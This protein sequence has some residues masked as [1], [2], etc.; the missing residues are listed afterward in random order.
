[1][2]QKRSIKR[3]YH[4][5]KWR[6][7]PAYLAL[8]GLCAAALLLLVPVAEASE[9]V[10]LTPEQRAYLAQLGPLTV[11]PDPDWMPFEFVDADGN[12]TGIAA[13]LLDL[14]EQRLGIEFSYVIPRD[15]DEA[16]EWSQA[17]EV[18]IL[19]FLNQSPAREEW[20]VF[21]EPLF[22]DPNVFITRNEHPFISDARQLSNETMVLPS[23][24]SIEERVRAAFPNLQIVT[25][26]SEREVFQMI[27]SGEAQLTLRSMTI[28]AYTIR[29]QG[30]FNLRINGQAPD[31]FINYLRMGVLANEPMLRDILNAG[32]ATITP[33]E[34]EQI[35]NRHVNITVVQPFDYTYVLR[36]AGFIAF[37]VALALLWNYRLRSL[38]RALAES[39]RSK[40]VLLSNLPGMAYKCRFDEHWTMEFISQGCTELTGYQPEDL[41]D[42]QQLSFKDLIDPAY[43]DYCDTTWR[44]ARKSGR[45]ARLEYPIITADGGQKWVFEQGVIVEDELPEAK[46]EGLII[47]I[48]NRKEAETRLYHTS[49][50][51]ELTGLFNR[52]HIVRRLTG[53][54]N[55]REVDERDFALAIID[56]DHFK[57]VNDHYGHLG[58][59]FVLSE[60]G[61]ILKNNFRDHDLVGRYG[62]E[63]FVVVVTGVNL[64]QTY[65]LF[66]RLL[67]AVRRHAFD[68][69]D[70]V[71]HITI[72][73][74]IVN[75]EEPALKLGLEPLLA[76]ADQ[77]LYQ[78]KQAGRDRFILGALDSGERGSKTARVATL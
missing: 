74:G 40:D 28:S 8:T 12:F 7:L 10:T 22:I 68:Y 72:S 71:I 52:R 43:Q 65:R 39:E 41:I 4:A 66:S 50:H 37:L 70:Q 16:L 58:G 59:D 57:K 32:I 55:Q 38:N 36:I 33:Q 1:M 17:G 5:P 30:L 2:R 27:E 24:T 73:A 21:T 56:I 76:L 6:A 26:P 34:R 42:N 19:P 48:T 75:T 60:L 35:A 61:R 63:E 64:D 77:R 11:A 29:S 69:K 31:E 51:D 23:G 62:G 9:T 46:I 15:W 3:F 53:F 44:E 13:D 25:V 45:P 14:L 78:A 67:E 49:T 18:L 47:D 54:L 20:L